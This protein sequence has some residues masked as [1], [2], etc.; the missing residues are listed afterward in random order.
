MRYKNRSGFTL[1]ELLV[2]IAIIAI[3]AGVVLVSVGN[4]RK[5]AIAAKQI[6]ILDSFCSKAEEW[7]A[8]EGSQPTAV[9]LGGDATGTP[10]P[11]GFSYFDT[12]DPKASTVLNNVKIGKFTVT[13]DTG[14]GDKNAGTYTCEYGTTNSPD[15]YVITYSSPTP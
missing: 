3:L 15:D 2:V 13:T 1:V 4:S 10:K 11:S 8:N 12:A 14:V 9:Q 7:I 5:K 6:A